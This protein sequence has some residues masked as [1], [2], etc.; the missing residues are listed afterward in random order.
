MLCFERNESFVVLSMANGSVF[1]ADNGKTSH[2]C[3]SVEKI[4]VQVVDISLKSWC[5]VELPTDS[6]T[7]VSMRKG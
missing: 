6:V 5:C 3:E 1:V 4:M 2:I 7:S